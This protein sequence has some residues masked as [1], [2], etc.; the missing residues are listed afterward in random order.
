MNIIFKQ[1]LLHNLT[2]NL[3]VS[4]I[5]WE[6][7]TYDY[8]RSFTIVTLNCDKAVKI[9]QVQN[10]QRIRVLYTLEYLIVASN[11]GKSSLRPIK[12]KVD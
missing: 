1:L 11:S 3:K 7:I 6:E 4:T 12:V 2:V 5:A 8:R 10:W 9:Y